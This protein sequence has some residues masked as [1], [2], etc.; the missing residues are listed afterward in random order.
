MRRRWEVES[1]PTAAAN[2]ATVSRRR[3]ATS[4]N[5]L[6][7][8]VF[9]EQRVLKIVSDAKQSWLFKSANSK[10]QPK[11]FVKA[12]PKI[13]SWRDCFF[14]KSSSCKNKRKQ[15]A[16]DQHR[17]NQSSRLASNCLQVGVFFCLRLLA[18]TSSLQKIAS[19]L[20]RPCGLKDFAIWEDYSVWQRLCSLKRFCSL[21][22]GF[23]LC[24]LQLNLNKSR[25]TEIFNWVNKSTA[26]IGRLL[27]K[28]RSWRCEISNQILNS[29][30][31]KSGQP[32]SLGL[33]NSQQATRSI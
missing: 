27:M 25:N 1:D 31:S 32:S 15:L 21:K 26:Y 10:Q 14:A 19:N 13:V 30:S 8:F 28:S 5:N 9:N 4:N 24:A 17:W 29:S 11:Q 16:A 22:E 7:I 23:A 2:W 6:L 12:F 33:K 20:K 3:L 18:Y